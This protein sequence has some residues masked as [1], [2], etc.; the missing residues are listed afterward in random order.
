MVT[1]CIHGCLFTRDFATWVNSWVLPDFGLGW[2]TLLSYLSGLMSLHSL[3]APPPPLLCQFS[4]FDP[5]F[6]S[7]VAKCLKDTFHGPWDP[8]SDPRTLLHYS[9]ALFLY[10]YYSRPVHIMHNLYCMLV[11][12]VPLYALLCLA[13]FVQ[14]WV[15]K[16]KNYKNKNNKKSCHTCI[17]T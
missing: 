13:C 8:L 7:F 11:I 5:S 10:A 9:K 16:Q 1:F 17:C 3:L 14:F 2:A 15:H 12:Y 4:F 6:S